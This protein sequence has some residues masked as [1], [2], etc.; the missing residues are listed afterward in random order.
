MHRSPIHIQQATRRYIPGV[1][2]GAEIA[3]WGIALRLA[4]GLSQRRQGRHSSAGRYSGPLEGRLTELQLCITEC[5]WEAHH[6][7]FHCRVDHPSMAPR[8]SVS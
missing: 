5:T 7:R 8:P 6:E 2:S 1:G 4:Q 3:S